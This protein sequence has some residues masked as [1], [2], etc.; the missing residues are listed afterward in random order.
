MTGIR[1]TNA[2]EKNE[3]EKS[4]SKR[5]DSSGSRRAMRAPDNS[6]AKPRS[7]TRALVRRGYLAHSKPITANRYVSALI[8][9]TGAALSV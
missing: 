5:R 6:R 3:K 9:K 8:A 7:A 1:P 2:S 4:V